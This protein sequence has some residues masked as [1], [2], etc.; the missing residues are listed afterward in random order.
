MKSGLSFW[1]WGVALA[2]VLALAVPPALAQTTFGTIVGNVTDQTD[3]L[4][5]DAE[6][7]V[8]NLGT[9]LVTK[10]RVSAAGGYRVGELAPGRYRLEVSKAGFK[11]STSTIT[12]NAGVVHRLDFVMEV[13]NVTEVMTVESQATEVATD[14]SKLAVTIG[15][16]QVGNLPLNGRNVYSLIQLAPGA[17][18]VRGVSFENGQGTVVNGLRPNFNGFLINGSSNKGLSGGTVTLPNPDIVEEFQMLTLNMSAQYGNSAGS[19]TNIITKSG[20][21]DFH[22]TAFYF[23]R[24][25]GLDANDFFRNASGVDRTPVD[26]NQF[27][28]TFTG[29][30]IKD[31]LFFTG[32]YQGQRFT[33]DSDAVPILIE[34]SA[35]RQAVIAAR[36]NSVAALIYNNFAPTQPGT[37]SL[38]LDQFVAGGFSGSGFSSFF[39]YL[40]SANYPTAFQGLATQFAGLFGVT[41]AENAAFAGAGCNVLPVQAGSISRTVPFLND[42]VA[43]FGSQAQGNL[44]NGNEWSTRID[45]VSRGGNDRVTGEYY[46]QK[47]T[48]KFGPSNASSGPH[49]FA[50]PQESFTPNYS[51]SWVHTFTPN[52]VNEAR[53]GYTRAALSI[54]V[55]VPG[56]P[57]IG[58]DDGSAGFGSYNGYPQF[59]FENIYTY[60]DML[61][62]QKGKHSLKMGADFRRNYE[63]STF[64]VGRPSYLF[65]DQLF[66]ALDAP[67]GEIAGT[68]PG[69]S[70]GA[71]ARLDENNRAWRNFEIGLYFQDDWKL[72]RD[73]TINAGIRFDLYTRHTEKFDRVTTW[74]PGP[75]GVTP[76]HRGTYFIESILNANAPCTDPRRVL[77]GVCGPGGFSVVDSLGG[78]DHNNFGP[79][80]GVAWDIGGKGKYVLRGG[81]GVSFE[82]TLYNPLSNSRWNPPFFSFNLAFNDLIGG[83]QTVVYGPTTLNA[84]GQAVPSGAQPTFT[85]QQNNLGAGVG[86]A[87]N[88]GN[89]QGWFP[90]NPNTAFLTGIVFPKGIR[91]PYI[92][93]YFVGV[94]YEFLKNTVLEVNWVATRGYK[95]FRAEQINRFP[96]VRF[97]V[98]TS[99]TVQGRQLTGFGRQFL[100]PNYGVLRAWLNTSRS[101]YD[102]LQVTVRRAMRNGLMFN[103]NYAW[104]HSIDTGSGWHSGAVTANGAAAG[105]GYSLDPTRPE[106]DKGNSTFDIRHRFTLNY[107]WELPW[108]K[109]QQGAAGKILGGWQMNGIVSLQS[110]AHWTPFDHRPRN[111]QAA[112]GGA[113]TDLTLATCVNLGGDYNFDGLANDRPNAP[114]GNHIN[115]GKC[116]YANGYFNSACGSSF[117]NAL[118][119]FGTPCLGCNGNLGRN[120]FE[121]P[122][123]INF[124]WSMMKNTTIREGMKVQFRFEVFNA[125]NRVN[126]ILPSSSTGANFAN[127]IASGIFGKSAGTLG[128]RNIQFGFKFQF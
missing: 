125:F 106:L 93:N 30:I 4:I 109:S 21:N 11:K 51:S 64:N 74:I 107:V 2:I 52:V 114:N 57:S 20:T 45:W 91:D 18:D 28:G 124:D 7:T 86:G 112:A 120:T 128:P 73:L 88:E 101:W 66:F 13:G 76:A 56:V 68:D 55:A 94:Q 65:F 14:D 58:F 9:N 1:R 113:C 121:G 40:C 71:G 46:W 77:A 43:S 50:N 23:L 44:T 32:S 62:M 92:H 116:E 96:G 117:S 84:M 118:S 90:T 60:S 31:K 127:R 8:T 63:N 72:R 111:L 29:R 81:Y 3:A 95:L 122:G 97:P 108:Y 33:T 103:A 83:G 39:D 19:L 16:G 24:R 34:N 10:V 35:W 27:G 69:F 67:Y 105:D 59:F 75:G 78:S 89:I 36:P 6:I 123:H 12:V 70:R 87:L 110:G 102:G 99:V 41:A 38:T 79:R 22:G 42:S 48:D 119:F 82:G 25:D 37:L 15:S 100:N 26:F 53:A 98:G 115:G 47:T 5:P 80:A 61:S 49:G 85:G 126:F 104:S 54:D 17:S